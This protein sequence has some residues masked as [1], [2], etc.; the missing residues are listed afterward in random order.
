[1][2]ALPFALRDAVRGLR[3]DRV[4]ALTVVVTLAL[5]IGAVTAVF[6]IV[7][8]V[9]LKPLDY[10][11]PARLVTLREIWRQ[12]DGKS[13]SYEV[14]ER[15]FEYWRAHARSFDAMAQYI[16]RAG[17]LT[18]AGEPAEVSVAHASGSLFDVLQTR[19]AIGRTFTPA[20]EP[21]GRPEVAVISDA[22]WRRRF[23]SNP[24]IVGRTIAI[25]GT[26]RTVVG[27]LGQQ[28]AL[29]AERAA[30]GAE[31][32][33]PI[34]MDAEAVGWW[35][36]HNNEAI[37][38][39]RRGVSPEQARAELDVLQQQVGAIATK[40]AHEPVTLASVVTPLA[41]AVVGRAR[42][43]LLF[44]LAA[45]AAVLLIACSNLANLSLTREIRRAREAAVRAA[46]GAGRARLVAGA[47]IEQ[48]LLSAAGGVL[49]IAVAWAA[50][51]LFVRTA[52]IDLPRVDDAPI[53]AR[54][55]A[56]AAAVSVGAG[57]VVAIVPAWR[58]ARR[59]VERTLRAGAL[60]T[61]TDRG[62]ARTRAALLAAQVALSLALVV[63]T[64][65]LGTSFVRVMHVD[66]GFVADRVLLVPISLPADRYATA[67]SLVAAYDRLLAAVSAV[68]GVRAASTL[69]MAPL[70]GTGQVNTIAA[71]GDPLPRSQQPSANFRFV[72]P[73]FFQAIGIAVLR[74]RAFADVDRQPGRPMPAVISA[75]TA[76]RLWPRQDPIGR[77][78]SRDL[79]GEA[80]FEVVG[81]VADAK[82]TSLEQ[83]PPLLV[84]LPYWWRA[85]AATSLAIKTAVDPA[86]LAAPVGRAVHGVDPAIA[87]GEARPLAGMVDA[88][89]APRRY[90]MRLFAAFGAV[91]L[92]IAMLGVYAVT[93]YG[94][95]ERRRELHIRSALGARRG[96]LLGRAMRQAIVPVGAGVGAGAALALALG[97]TIASMLFDVAPRDPEVLGG[98]IAIVAAISALACFTA[99]RQVLAIQPAEALRE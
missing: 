86:A 61:T 52:P 15:H 87:V 54:V 79:P 78:F 95:S 25:D 84:Y 83:T 93:A 19:A 65:L 22:C 51:R 82:I 63:V 62:G 10:P 67:P 41:E 40:E 3:R 30:L 4:F 44:L 99:A 28:F 42:R 59:D 97:G 2:M 14:N 47:A 58:A 77:H 5:T 76:A 98:A 88:S 85:R 23:G 31:V 73:A 43:G 35:G 48:L 20:D 66:R 32:F 27:V 37:G 6:S 80:G 55:L 12:F 75:E 16:V 69:S 18:G 74:G 9:L 71:D 7:D 26:P 49:G 8:G 53:D 21:S 94:V 81:I 38:R 46:L 57:V 96:Q 68:P 92:F 45:I 13:P 60:A 11:D 1:M 89:I 72:A 64:V 33:V 90:Q 24:A 56:F 39:L 29:P 17:N 34:H 91:A 70:T 36:D 50:L